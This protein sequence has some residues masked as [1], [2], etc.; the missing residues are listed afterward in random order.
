[1]QCYIENIV[2][3]TEGQQWIADKMMR[4][5]HEAVEKNCPMIPGHSC[6]E[7]ESCEA[8]EAMYCVKALDQLLS[9]GGDMENDQMCM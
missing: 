4:I 1:M 2:N 5:I 9:E 8:D 3:C 7:P 6:R